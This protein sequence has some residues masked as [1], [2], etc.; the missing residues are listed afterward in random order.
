MMNMS[1]G[2][3]MGG[4]SIRFSDRKP[5]LYNLRAANSVVNGDNK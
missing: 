4:N 5:I 2:L 1:R 3:F